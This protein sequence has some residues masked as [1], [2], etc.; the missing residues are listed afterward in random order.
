M[1]IEIDL[2]GRVVL[3]TGGTR[4]IG[5]GIA[6]TFLRAGAEVYV[7]ARKPVEQLPASGSNEARFIEVD[8]REGEQVAQLV[9]EI[10]RRSGRLD[11]VVNNAGGTPVADTVT[12]SIRLHRKVVELNLIAPL[13]LAQHA[14]DA[15][16]ETHGSIINI[17]SVSGRRPSPGTAAYGAAKAGLDNLTGSLAQ[18]L[19]PDV[20]VNGVV[21]GLV[22]SEDQADHYGQS[23]LTSIVPLGRLAEPSDV[24]NACLFLASPLASYISGSTL[25]VDGGGER[26]AY[27]NAVRT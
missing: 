16:A 9:E 15:L 3:V 14:R 10:Q 13:L 6:E 18:E 27:L 12:A 24:G 25:A 20:R 7:C 11:V 8:V 23:D 21:V 17:S 19:A 2:T 26:T 5:A 1:G 4:G 22:R